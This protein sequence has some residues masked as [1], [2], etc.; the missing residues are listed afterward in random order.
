MTQGLELAQIALCT[1]DMAGSL[2]FYSEVFGF[3]NGGSNAGWGAITGIQGLDPSARFLVWWLVGRQESVQVELFHHSAP[4]QR[5][6][7][8]DWTPADHGWVR[9][10]IGVPDFDATL[11]A[12]DRWD[13]DP[14]APPIHVGAGRRAAIRDPF[15]GMIIEIIEESDDLAPAL[16]RRHFDCDPFV[17][18]AAVSVSDLDAARHFYGDIVGLTLVDDN[19][20]HSP[21]HEAMWGLK[22]SNRRGLVANL[23]GIMLEIV[24]YQNP[25]GRPKAAN[26]RICDQGMMNVALRSTDT[27][28]I[29]AIVAKAEADGSPPNALIAMGDI[30]STYIQHPD[31]E[32]ELLGAPRTADTAL[33]F[34]PK[35][36]LIGAVFK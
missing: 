6:Q 14:I 13:I 18:Y 2:R 36:M 31:R 20:L 35:D 25:R 16:R 19:P 1:R 33:G 15:A 34:V 7:P 22:G 24:E 11:A 28:D 30:V 21:E 10:G 17:I 8:A 4:E 27:M 3:T 12:L 9:I 5:P 26:H 23:N 29:R 32:V